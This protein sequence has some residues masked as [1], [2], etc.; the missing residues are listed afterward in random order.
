MGG[1][2]LRG[3]LTSSEQRWLYEEI[4]RHADSKSDDMA[5][6]RSTLTRE[7]HAQKNAKNSP[8]PFVCWVHPYARRS[9]ACKKPARLLEWA[10]RL[11]HALAPGASR[12]TI[13]SMVAQLYHSG[14]SLRPHLDENLSWGLSLSLGSPATFSCEGASPITLRSGDIVVAEFGK[15][16]HAVK[17]SDDMP[18]AWWAQ[19]ETFGPRTRCNVLFRR[20]LSAKRQRNMCEERALLVHGMSVA[21]LCRRTGKAEAWFLQ[22]L[23]QLSESDIKALGGAKIPIG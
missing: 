7:S 1:C 16:L 12:I 9:S 18:P 21:E 4:G 22:F 17:T 6:L 2:L 20:A 14:G 11:L 15:L 3:A 19:V 10:D 23:S 13:D 5:G 8:M